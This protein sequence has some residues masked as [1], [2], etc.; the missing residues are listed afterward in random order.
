MASIDHTSLSVSDFT[1][2]KAFYT[3]ALSPLGIS[4]H[5]G[6]LQGGHGQRRCGRLG[7]DGKPFFWLAGGGKTT[8]HVHLAFGANSR[9]EVD[10]FYKAAIAAGG[11]ENGAPGIR[12][13]IIRPLLRRLRARCRRPQHRGGLP[14]AGVGARRNDRMSDPNAR[15]PFRASTSSIDGGRPVRS[16]VSR[17]ISVRRSAGVRRAQF[18]ALQLRQDETVDG[19]GRP[20]R[21]RGRRGARAGARAGTTRSGAARR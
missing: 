21:R 8:P 15:P 10:A 9:A 1:A 4:V 13:T 2:A 20:T 17:R 5:D 18:R 14:Q 16:N 11:K 6:V 3:A 12:A 19:V 7:T